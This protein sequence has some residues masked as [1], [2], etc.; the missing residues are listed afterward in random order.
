MSVMINLLCFVII[1][2]II[3][4]KQNFVPLT[5]RGKFIGPGN[6]QSSINNFTHDLGKF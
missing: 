2:L 5:D 3:F 4:L 1:I 6:F